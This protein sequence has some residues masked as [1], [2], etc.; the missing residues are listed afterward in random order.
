[1]LRR[2]RPPSPPPAKR[3]SP[4]VSDMIHSLQSQTTDALERRREKERR[5]VE[6]SQKPVTMH[7]DVAQVESA[8]RTSPKMPTMRTQSSF[9]SGPMA[10]RGYE[11]EAIMF[12]GRRHRGSAITSA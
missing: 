12:A 4:S 10:V 1:M 9:G 5:F 8:E 11:G 7:Q 6:L 3:T 2:A